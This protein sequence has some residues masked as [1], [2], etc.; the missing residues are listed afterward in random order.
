MR[1]TALG[2]YSI[3][4]RLIARATGSSGWS[5]GAWVSS[6]Y[7]AMAPDSNSET[8]SSMRNTGT[9]LCGEM[10]RNQSGRL[11]GSICAKSKSIFFSRS[12]IAARCTQGQVLKL[13][14][15][16]FV[17]AASHEF[18]RE[19]DILACSRASIKARRAPPSSPF[20]H[21]SFPPRRVLFFA[22][23]GLSREGHE[24][25][26]RA[27][28]DVRAGDG[29]RPVRHLLLDDLQHMLG[30]GR[31]DGNHD[32]AIGLQLLKQ[33]R[34]YMVDGAGDDDLVEG[35]FLR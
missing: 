8:R 2:R 13:T 15:W 17:M 35:G 10:A 33:R 3:Q 6:R 31:P 29:D 20:R 22:R 30:A 32:D 12:T 1:S 21:A 25:D 28:I 4:A 26:R 14:S 7:S 19:R 24:G 9:L 18:V 5:R 23:Q 16:Y 27:M 11:S 34:G